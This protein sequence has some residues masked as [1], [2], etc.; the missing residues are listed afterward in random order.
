MRLRS[1][2]GAALAAVA[3]LLSGT[4]GAVAAVISGYPVLLGLG[5][6]A[7]L[8]V[9]AG[10]LV[11]G[12]PAGVLTAIV[13]QVAGASL[14]CT[15]ADAP[16]AGAVSVLGVLVFLGADASLLSLSLREPVPLRHLPVG[17]WAGRAG[18]AVAAGALS[19]ALLRSWSSPPD[20][21]TA[22]AFGAAALVLVLLAVL[23]ARS[24][25]TGTQP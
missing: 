22:L 18:V 8:L 6:A 21:S 4:G 13:L 16:S 15:L 24:T 11:F 23:V 9:L 7:T 2:A 5:V 12:R 1:P 10:A 17:V 14:A 20:A 19:Y 3:L 25:R